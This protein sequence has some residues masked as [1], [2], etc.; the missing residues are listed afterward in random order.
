MKR[1]F[2]VILIFVFA[3]SINAAFLN[4]PDSDK[5]SIKWYTKELSD[6]RV[7]CIDEAG[8]EI[9]INSNEMT[10]FHSLTLENLKSGQ[11]YIYYVESYIGES[12]V[13]GSE[14]SFS[15][16]DKEAFKFVIYGDSRSNFKNHKKIC[17]GIAISDPLLVI[18]VGD[19]VFRDALIEDWADFYKSLDVLSSSFYYSAVGNHEM[20]ANNYRKLLDLPENELYYSFQKGKVLFIVLNTNQRF[21]RYSKQYLW[22][23]DVLKNRNPEKTEFTIVVTHHPPYSYSSHGDSYFLKL[24]L[25]PLFEEHNIDLVVSGHDHNYQRIEKGNINYIVTGGGGA[26]VSSINADPDDDLVKG[27]AVHHYVVFDYSPGV[28]KAEVIDING[29]VIDSF[30]VTK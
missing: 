15:M 14:G 25:V 4:R 9:H 18:N 24:I 26:H 19:L 23:T 10:N 16:E 3:V 17:K 6:S 21:D 27:Y 11:E 30:S 1:I 28:I 29:D 13:Y 8:N 7:Y 2:F 22:L 20:S 5:V 12:R